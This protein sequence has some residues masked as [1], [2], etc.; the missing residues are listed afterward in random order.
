MWQT[1]FHEPI[2]TDLSP[3]RQPI[4]ASFLSRQRSKKELLG[5]NLMPS[6]YPELSSY[7]LTTPHV[8]K[9]LITSVNNYTILYSPFTSSPNPPHRTD[10]MIKLWILYKDSQLRKELSGILSQGI[11][12][13]DIYV[14]RVRCFRR[15]C[16]KLSCAALN[17]KFQTNWHS[18]NRQR[19]L[20]TVRFYVRNSVATLKNSLLST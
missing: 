4:R 18:H 9:A 16:F 20:K 14:K 3:G 8:T 7:L 19:L 1:Y 15:I 11:R 6:N 17:S 12:S 13:T 5:S 2:R 10:W